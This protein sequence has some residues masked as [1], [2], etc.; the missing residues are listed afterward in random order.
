MTIHT[1]VVVLGLGPGGEDAAGRLCEAGLDVVGV[2]AELVG[3]ECPYWG[4]VPSKMMIRAANLLAEARRVDSMAGAADVRPDWGSVARRIRE[5]AT[6]S[7]DDTVAAK[8]FE[9][10]G[11]RLLRG[12]GRLD[13][14]GRVVVDDDVIEAGRAVV[15][16]VGARAWIPPIDGLAGTPFWTNREAIETTEV[17]ASLIVL[18]GG[19]IGVELAQVFGRFGAAVTV[20]EAGPRIVG[21]EEPEAS[22]VLTSVLQGEGINV[23]T[24]AT[25]EAVRYADEQFTVSIAGGAPVTASKLLVAVGRRAD[26]HSLAVSSVG[27]DEDAAA[28]PTDDHLR[29]P[30]VERTWALGDVTGKGA[31]THMSMYQA[32]IVVTDILGG[33]VVPADYHAVP[34]VTFTDPEIGSVG[35][36]EA[37]AR[38][39]GLDVRTGSASIP[40]SARGWI[41]KAGN[42]GLIKVV[43]DTARGVLVGATSMGPSGGEVLGFLAL[44]VAA[45]VPTTQLRHMPYAYPTFHRAI[46]SAIKDLEA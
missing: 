29:V 36:S 9:D 26:L 16:A 15:I 10:K 46:E 43:E 31:F 1:D 12:W 22:E 40:S 2:E 25:V 45:G 39:H 19:A 6:D 7:W 18:G 8:R 21:P 32:D 35:L 34:R 13:G 30:G 4:C 41:H 44:A 24:S 42:E 38:S 5:E 11:G 3:G 14:P 17:P 23:M 27:L 28:V 20:L 37:A 33:D